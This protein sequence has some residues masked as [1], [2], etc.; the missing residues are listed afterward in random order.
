M[1]DDWIK[2]RESLYE[3]PAVLKMAHL[4][5]ERPEHIVGYL[6]RFWSWVSRNMS[7]ENRDKCPAAS[8]TGVPL[9]SV[10]SVLNL[11]KFLDT[12]CQVG[13][14]EY[15]DSGPEPI[16]TIPKFERHL[17]QSA[18]RRALEAEK[19]RLQRA[20]CPEAVQEMSP[21]NRDNNGTRVEKRR[22]DKSNKAPPDASASDTPPKKFVK[23][24]LAEVTAYCLERGR[25]INPEAWLAHY[26]ANGWKCGRHP[27]KNWRAAVVKWESSEWAPKAEVSRVPTIED[28]AGWNPSGPPKE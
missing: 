10:E 28:M 9:L 26:E 12:M 24:T 18:K 5:G 25:G 13:W 11:P 6:H 4:R 17:S 15:D 2:M 21:D 22:E 19:K 20:T 8:V 1:A 27:M 23:P 7:P 14:L 16:I 3:D